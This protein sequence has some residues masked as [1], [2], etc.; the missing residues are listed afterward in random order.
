MRRRKHAPFEGT[1]CEVSKHTCI[2]DWRRWE[3]D[4]GA[5]ARELS[6]YLRCGVGREGKKGA[7][8]G[9]EAVKCLWA[10]GNKYCLKS[11]GAHETVVA[12]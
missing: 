7:K 1:I 5:R 12:E 6:R 4:I 11:R 2:L 9:E 10:Y 8:V 3:Q